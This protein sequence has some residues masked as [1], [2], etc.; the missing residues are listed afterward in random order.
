[1]DQIK[2]PIIATV[3]MMISVP[4]FQTCHI[5]PKIVTFIIIFFLF[6]HFPNCVLI[7]IRPKQ[8]TGRATVDQGSTEDN[9]VTVTWQDHTRDKDEIVITIQEKTFIINHQL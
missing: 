9:R 6:G 8:T 7:F 2:D 1:M 5:R 4:I 3:L